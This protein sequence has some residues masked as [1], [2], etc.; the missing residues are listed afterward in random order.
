MTLHVEDANGEIDID[1]EVENTRKINSSTFA[2]K[3]RFKHINFN[4][5][6][7]LRLLI[8]P[9]VGLGF[10]IH[11]FVTNYLNLSFQASSY[12]YF[13][14]TSQGD[15]TFYSGLASIQAA[16][17]SSQPLPVSA[18]GNYI[19][20]YRDY[21]NLHYNTFGYID[22]FHQAFTDIFM[23][24]VCNGTST[25][26]GSTQITQSCQ[27]PE[28]YPNGSY[29]VF[30]DMAIKTEF[31]TDATSLTYD[32]I[33][34][35]DVLSQTHRTMTNFLITAENNYTNNVV[36]NLLT[37]LIVWILMMILVGFLYGVPIM[38][39]FVDEIN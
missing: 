28:L 6:I 16:T 10:F 20:Y 3:K 8:I 33:L 38:K 36:S 34:S 2:K 32:Y 11:S 12:H 4:K 9:I 31:L 35:N 1:E 29:L 19:L 37:A 17:L 24:D 14:L 18:S 21:Y 26:Y 13:F 15:Y 39:R 30:T 27:L 5:N 7:Y 22:D 23:L 25:A